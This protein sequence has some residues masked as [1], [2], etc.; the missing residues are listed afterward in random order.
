MIPCRRPPAMNSMA[1]GPAAVRPLGDPSFGLP[2]AGIPASPV[3]RL[4][5]RRSG[6]TDVMGRK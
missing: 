6:V 2:L 5:I 4:T 1:T 3:A